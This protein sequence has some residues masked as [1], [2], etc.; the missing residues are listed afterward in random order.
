[1][2]RRVHYKGGRSLTLPF[3]RHL[4]AESLSMFFEMVK[5]GIESLIF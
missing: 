1:M 4:P 2:S 3:F 5:T